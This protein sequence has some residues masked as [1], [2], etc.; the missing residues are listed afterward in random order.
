MRSEAETSSQNHIKYEN[1]VNITNPERVIRR[2]TETD[3][4][5]L[6][7]REDLP[8]KGEVAKPRSSG[9]QAFPQ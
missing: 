7:K 5:H 9:T 6:E 1:T 3:G 4:L 2:K 8:E